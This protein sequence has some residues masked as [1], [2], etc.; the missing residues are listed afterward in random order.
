MFLPAKIVLKCPNQKQCV[1]TFIYSVHPRG[2]AFTDRC[3]GHHVGLPS[4]FYLPY[5]VLAGFNLLGMRVD[6]CINKP[7]ISI[8]VTWTDETIYRRFSYFL[9]RALIVTRFAVRLEIEHIDV[10]LKSRSSPSPHQ[11]PTPVSPRPTCFRQ[12]R[13][14]RRKK[15]FAEILGSTKAPTY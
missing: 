4:S 2:Q 7:P 6:P 9:E 5:L 13:E 1:G 10:R 12:S 11:N 8:R 3:L 14:H 15:E